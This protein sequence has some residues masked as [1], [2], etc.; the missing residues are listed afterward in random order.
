MNPMITPLHQVAQKIAIEKRKGGGGTRAVPELIKAKKTYKPGSILDRISKQINRTQ[1]A[2]NLQHIK[3]DKYTGYSGPES[4][5]KGGTKY[6]CRS[7]Y[8]IDIDDDDEVLGA[9]TNENDRGL[10]VENEDDNEGGD[11]DD[12]E[13]G[14]GDDDGNEVHDDDDEGD[15]NDNENGDGEEGNEDG[16]DNDNEDGDEG[17]EDGDEGD[18]DD[19]EN[20]TENGDDNETEKEWKSEIEKTKSAVATTTAAKIKSTIASKPVVQYMNSIMIEGVPYK[21]EFVEEYC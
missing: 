1:R 21:N 8:N 17:N 3:R 16:D 7:R 11:D 12:N 20:E 9:D 15:G 13:G 14:V 2:N 5:E 18:E 6:K 4:T 10:N 19:N